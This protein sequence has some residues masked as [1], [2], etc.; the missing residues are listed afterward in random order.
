MTNAVLFFTDLEKICLFA[1]NE[2][3]KQSFICIK[4]LQMKD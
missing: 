2:F 1:V 4:Y 3:A